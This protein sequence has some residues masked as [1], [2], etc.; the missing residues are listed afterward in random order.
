[1]SD[2]N[3]DAVFSPWAKPVGMIPTFARYQAINGLKPKGIHVSL[4]NSLLKNITLQ[5]P[6]QRRHRAARHLRRTGR[7][8]AACEGDLAET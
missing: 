5:V 8:V 4:A 2:H 6:D 7:V 1:M 3:T